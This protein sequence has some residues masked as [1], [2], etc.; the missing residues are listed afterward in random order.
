MNCSKRQTTPWTKSRKKPGLKKTEKGEHFDESNKK[1]LASSDKGSWFDQPSS[2]VSGVSHPSTSREVGASSVKLMAS[3]A[4][5]SGLAESDS[6]S[7]DESNGSTESE[8]LE[9][10]DEA[11]TWTVVDHLKINRKLQEIASCRFFG[12]D[13]IRVEEESR[14]GPGAEWSFKC[15]N[16]GCSSHHISRSF[17]TTPKQNRVYGINRG[18]VLGLR[19]IGRRHSAAERLMSALNLSSPVGRAPWSSHTKALLK[20][21]NELL[22]TELWNAALEVKR[23]KVVNGSLVVEGA[24]IS[25]QEL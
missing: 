1:E 2:D 14:C 17:H 16:S 10:E 24:E 20:A 6:T 11:N 8:E 23:F 15:R 19:L 22:D 9:C 21:A 4:S 3:K 5:T 12:T 25:D 7:G 13:E 18:L